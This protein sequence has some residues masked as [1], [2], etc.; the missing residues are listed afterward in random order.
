MGTEQGSIFDINDVRKL[1]RRPVRL[2]RK[3]DDLSASGGSF[4]EVGA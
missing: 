3:P 2:W 1:A 4:S